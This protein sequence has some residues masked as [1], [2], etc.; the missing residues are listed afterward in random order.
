MTTGEKLSSLRKQ[1]N[2]T[3]EELADIMNVSRQSVS[4]WESDI[5]FP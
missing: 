1:N 5:A 3:Q 4:R 2:Y